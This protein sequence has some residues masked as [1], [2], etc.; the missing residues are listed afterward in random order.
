MPDLS[1][2]HAKKPT[3]HHKGPFPGRD[4]K[5]KPVIEDFELPE[6]PKKKVPCIP[7]EKHDQHRSMP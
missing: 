1:D 3:Y 6:K 2:V 5:R 4:P 7:D